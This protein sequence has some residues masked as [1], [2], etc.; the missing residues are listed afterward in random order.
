MEEP[1]S[2]PA[3]QPTGQPGSRHRQPAGPEW[4]SEDWQPKYLPFTGEPG[5]HSG[6]ASEPVDFFELFLTDELLRH[7]VVQTNLYATQCI[8]QV[9]DLLPCTLHYRVGGSKA[10]T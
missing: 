8:A 9:G 5:P 6:L 1:P 4:C 10:G 7:I 2:R 3:S